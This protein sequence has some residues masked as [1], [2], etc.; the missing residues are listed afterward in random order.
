[1][2]SHIVSARSLQLTAIAGTAAFGFA[3][4]LFLHF[5]PEGQPCDSY[6]ECLHG[7]AC[8]DGGC[9]RFTDAC[10]GCLEGQR[11]RGTAC[12]ED[13]CV[14]RL[15]PV[16]QVCITDSQG[17]RCR[18]VAPPALMHACAGDGDCEP[19][20]LCLV[21]TV[22]S[23]SGAPRTGI[24]VEACDP[25]GIVPCVTT[26]AACHA[27]FFGL[28][29]GSQGLC[30]PPAAVLECQ[31]D[32]PCAS[33]GFVCAV[34]GHPSLS[35]IGLCDAPLPGGAAA[36]AACSGSPMPGPLCASGLCAP[37][38]GGTCGVLCAGT[39]A[40]A[41]VCALA[42]LEVPPG[43]PARHVPMCLARAHP[44]RGLLGCS[45]G[46]RRRCATLHVLRRAAG[47]P[48]RLRR[49]RRGHRPRLPGRDRLR[50]ARRGPALRPTLGELPVAAHPVAA[51]P[52]A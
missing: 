6:G 7:Y 39:C 1:M 12:V 24:C 48:L 11:C 18:S 50:R 29:A 45:L 14:N 36:G 5:D 44:L 8:M 13:T 51:G 28:D 27:F 34:F 25:S 26:S 17:T 22:L 41:N 47:V 2:R 42:E 9:H 19:G 32:A 33:E 35:P 20:R 10:G 52:Q 49:P 15:C 21:G 31:S 40:P 3:C 46:V 23:K 4:S 16:G 37:A 30:L 38:S 43:G